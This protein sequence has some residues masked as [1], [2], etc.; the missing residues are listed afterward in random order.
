MFALR[1]RISFHDIHAYN[2]DLAGGVME[3]PMF[4]T[5][6]DAAS[7]FVSRN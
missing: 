1:C 7:D 5:L 6:E 2:L 3:H 4:R